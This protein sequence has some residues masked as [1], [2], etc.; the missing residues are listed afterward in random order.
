MSLPLEL[1]ITTGEPAGIGPEI[2]LAAAKQF[3]QENDAVSIT[4]LGDPSLFK[5]IEQKNRC[6]GRNNYD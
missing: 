6:L 3:L 2:A 4:L 5:A 1:V